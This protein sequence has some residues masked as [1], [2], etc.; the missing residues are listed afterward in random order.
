M[1]NRILLLAVLQFWLS[2]VAAF[3]IMQ[4][5]R[6]PDPPDFAEYGFVPVHVA[7]TKDFW[8][9][10]KKEDLDKEALPG[11]RQVKQIARD[12][13]RVQARYLVLDIE[14]WEVGK[15]TTVANRAR[16]RDR[17][18][19]TARLFKREL[20]E[21]PIGY[22]SILPIRDYWRV[23]GSRTSEKYR[24][25]LSENDQIKAMGDE[26][27]ALFPSLYTFYPKVDGWV[28]YATEN[29][30]LARELAGDKKVI[31]FLWP[32]Y[33][34]SNR[35]LKKTFIDGDYWRTQLDTCHALADGIIIWDSPTREPWDDS[36]PWW[37]QTVAFLRDIG[38][39]PRPEAARHE[40]TMTL[41]SAATVPAPQASA[42]R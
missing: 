7:Y 3:E 28:R 21:I 16:S 27:D 29:L 1:L 36:F 30:L 5:M 12:A 19:A 9:R 24:Q 34:V 40:H 11:V 38:H 13:R 18:I 35:L 41:D 10:T 14:H 33:H 8:P 31:C 20:P 37:Q 25:W 4:D 32:R 15:K 2:A 22:Y 39:L 6:F 23:Q 26:V 42:A 17:Y